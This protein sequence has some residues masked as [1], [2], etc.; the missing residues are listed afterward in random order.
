[1][2]FINLKVEKDSD[3]DLTEQQLIKWWFTMGSVTEEKIAQ[4]ILGHIKSNLPPED[5]ESINFMHY[6]RLSNGKTWEGRQKH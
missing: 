5:L 2:L 3:S 1:M 6:Y 4:L